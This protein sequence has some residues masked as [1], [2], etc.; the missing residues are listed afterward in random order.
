LEISPN[1]IMDTRTSPGGIPANAQKIINGGPGKATVPEES[2]D[3]HDAHI[4]A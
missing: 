1:G 3:T 2:P 4:V